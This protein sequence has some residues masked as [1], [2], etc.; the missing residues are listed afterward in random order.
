MNKKWLYLIAGGM[1]SG[2]GIWLCLLAYRWLK[3][4]SI[5]TTLIFA[6][7][8][9]LLAG[10]IYLFGFRFFANRNILRINSYYQDRVCIFAFQQW[11]SYPLVV[12]MVSLGVFLRVYAP[13][14]KP[15]LAVLYIGIGGSLFMASF[16]YY[17]KLAHIAK[18]V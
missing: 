11:T 14:P 4:V 2:V 10:A 3:P 9:I 15:Y 16:L 5:N 8:G 12:M 13:I 18:K 17:R 6:A 7:V 1:W